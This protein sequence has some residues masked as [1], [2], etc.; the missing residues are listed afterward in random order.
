[1]EYPKLSEIL[2]RYVYYVL[3]E[4][5]FNQT[6]AANH[7]GVSQRTIRNYLTRIKNIDP[8]V[9]EEVEAYRKL[10][11]KEKVEKLNKKDFTIFPTNEERINYLNMM[12]NADRP[13]RGY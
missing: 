7:L 10:L 9:E 12:I 1:M 6:K 3:K 11:Q 13:K 5:G 8:S 4:S 2:N